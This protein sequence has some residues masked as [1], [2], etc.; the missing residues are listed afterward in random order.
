MESE[1]ATPVVSIKDVV[2]SSVKVPEFDKHLK[3][4]GG[5]IGQNI[6]EI[7]KDEDNSLKT[8]NDKNIFSILNGDS[9]LRGIS[10]ADSITMKD[11]K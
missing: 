4:A 9:L 1:Q 11:G 10:S 5:Y 2:R 8:F 7:T 6:M 3:K